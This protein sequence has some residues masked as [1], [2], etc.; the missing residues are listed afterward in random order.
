MTGL[1]SPSALTLDVIV[2]S[3]NTR[4]DLEA[5]LAALVQSPPRGLGRILV[6]DNAS[7]D[8]SPAAVVRGWPDVRLI[9]LPRNVGFG[10]ANNIAIRESDGALV[11]F[12]NSD[13][14]APPHAIDT[15]VERLMSTGA[16]AAGPRLIDD[17]GRPEVSFGSMLS[18]WAEIVQRARVG[19]A[20]RR[21][22]VSSWYI[23]RLLSREREVDWVTGACLLVRRQALVGAGLFD[24][25]YF[26]YEEDVDLCA[27]LRA[28]GGRILFTPHAQVL[29]RRGQ[30][31]TQSGADLRVLYNES[32]LR[33]YEKHRPGWARLLRWWQAL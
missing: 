3:H 20:H 2:V 27:A 28:R 33:F 21:G 4:A 24:E 6:V 18:P 29:H 31:I 13:A 25:R 17:E 19:A 7:T 1:G 12:L 8:G 16:V 10:A 11:L 22:G 9:A 5:C 15:L 14:I 32:H 30:S 23:Q 26:M